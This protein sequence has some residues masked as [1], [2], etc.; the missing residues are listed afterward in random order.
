MDGEKVVK[1]AVNLQYGLFINAVVQFV[2]VAFVIFLV[3]KQINRLKRD[4]PK[5]PTEKDCP[6]CCSRIPIKAIRCPHCTSEQV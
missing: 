1:P 6:M 5:E 2:I 3:V 4:V